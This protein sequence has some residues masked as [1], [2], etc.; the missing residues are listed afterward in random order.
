M[1]KWPRT[2]TE[3]RKRC[4]HPHFCYGV[5]RNLFDWWPL[6]VLSFMFTIDSRPLSLRRALIH[7]LPFMF[8]C[9]VEPCGWLGVRRCYASLYSVWRVDLVG[10][11]LTQACD[12]VNKQFVY[13]GATITLHQKSLQSRDQDLYIRTEPEA[14]HHQCLFW[15]QGLHG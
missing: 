6:T 10:F 1:L 3:K 14:G 4:G 15:S 8:A 7:S 11:L 13:S 9:R 12:V 2:S 5:S